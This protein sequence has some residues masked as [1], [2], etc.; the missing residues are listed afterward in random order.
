LETAEDTK[1]HIYKEEK[2]T[3]IVFTPLDPDIYRQLLIFFSAWQ[4]KRTSP[5]SLLSG[6][7]TTGTRPALYW[8][9]Q[10][11]QEFKQLAKY[12]GEDQP[13]Y[14]MRS[15]HN[16][17]QYTVE[18]LKNLAKHYANEIEEVDPQGPYILGGNC[19][20]SFIAYEI[21]LELTRKG[22]RVRHIFILD[23][24]YHPTNGDVESAFLS[25]PETS[26]MTFI[27]GEKSSIN[28]YLYHQAPANSLHKYLPQ[29]FDFHFLPC[30]HGQYFKEPN[31]QL[32][33]TIIQTQI[34]QIRQVSSVVLEKGLVAQPAAHPWS[35]EAYKA[36]LT[37]SSIPPKEVKTRDNLLLEITIEN[38]SMLPWV[39]GS[40]LGLGNHW[41]NEQ[42]DICQWLDGRVL[43]EDTLNPGETTTLSLQ[44]CVPNQAGKHII[45]LDLVEEGIT[46]F[47]S[48]GNSVIAIEVNI[49]RKTSPFISYL[50]EAFGKTE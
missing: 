31:V 48:K 38:Q 22:K 7:N 30:D 19:Q 8:C 39:A 45:E 40:G 43:L 15:G 5:Q 17:M 47:K 9:F 29:G 2:T 42:G 33:A 50:K 6:L 13:A 37:L 27:F 41:Y 25:Y 36:K 49:S 24:L 34:T 14:G 46:W 4:G 23:S 26:P 44:V 21:A 1:Q 11:F 16:V 18:N 3:S 35:E 32:L 28:P 12:L 10:G 20:S